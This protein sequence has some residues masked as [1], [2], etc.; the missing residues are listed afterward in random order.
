MA[1]KIT[2]KTKSAAKAP[3]KKRVNP[4][5]TWTGKSGE[6]REYGS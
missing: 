3:K 1:K 4:K 6:T 5:R 2:F